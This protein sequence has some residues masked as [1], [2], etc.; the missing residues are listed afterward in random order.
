MYQRTSKFPTWLSEGGAVC[1]TQKVLVPLLM[2]VPVECV[3][4]S[5]FHI[6]WRLQMLYFLLVCFLFTSELHFFQEIFFQQFSLIKGDLPKQRSQ[7]LKY[8]RQSLVSDLLILMV[9]HG[10]CAQSQSSP[11]KKVEMPK[12]QRAQRNVALE[13]AL[14]GRSLC[15]VKIR[16]S[17]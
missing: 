7:H 8:Q 11:G 2:P 16:V 12:N 9:C 15:G 13:K 5:C 14:W 3:S 1:S 17:V 10:E 4:S 6:G